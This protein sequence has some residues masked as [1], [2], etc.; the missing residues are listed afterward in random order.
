MDRSLKWRTVGLLASIVLCL[1]VLAPTFI[2]DK[3]P[4]WFPFAK[5][6]NLGLDLQGGLHIVYSIDLDGPAVDVH[7]HAGRFFRAV[8]HDRQVP[9]LLAAEF[10]LG[11]HF[12]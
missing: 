10:L 7:P 4:S 5:K 6:I 3:L 12:D 11:D 2:P 8:V 9:P 1:A